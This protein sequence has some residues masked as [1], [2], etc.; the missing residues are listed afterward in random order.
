MTPHCLLCKLS[1]ALGEQGEE[2]KV[3]VCYGFVF[4]PLLLGSSPP[5][6]VGKG[7]I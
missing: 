2:R 5:R 6:N 4:S 7:R 1:S 3:A